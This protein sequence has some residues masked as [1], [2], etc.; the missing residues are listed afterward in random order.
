VENS[1]SLLF[2][3][4]HFPT[5]DCAD[6]LIRETLADIAKEVRLNQVMTE[7]AIRGSTGSVAIIMRVLRGRLFFNVQ[8]TTYLTAQWD[9]EAPDTLASVTERYKV[10]GKLLAANGY[11]IPNPAATYW[12]VRKRRG[13][14]IWRRTFCL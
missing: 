2:S 6:S 4:G 3:E 1:V 5:F 12:F 8:D 14:D 7:A 10:S 9:P 11:E 13:R